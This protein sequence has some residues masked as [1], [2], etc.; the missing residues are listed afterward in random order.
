LKARRTLIT[1]IAE[2]T[3]LDE[4]M[5]EWTLTGYTSVKYMHV[6]FFFYRYIS[7]NHNDDQNHHNVDFNHDALEVVSPLLIDYSQ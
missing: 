7:T 3:F 5:D 4:F 2:E 1:E 6:F